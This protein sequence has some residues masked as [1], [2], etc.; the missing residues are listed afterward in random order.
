MKELLKFNH[1]GIELCLLRLN[2]KLQFAKKTRGELSF[3]LT[4]EERMLLLNVVTSFIP[5]DN[6]ITLYNL[7]KDGKKF[8]H[9]FD[10]KRNWHL[11][12][13]YKGTDLVMPSQSDLIAFNKMFNSQ[14]VVSY[15][16]G[17]DNKSSDSNFIKRIIRF[18][19]KNVI[20]M[21]AAAIT[22]T[23]G[24][25][26][27]KQN[28]EESSY[29]ISYDEI[30][31]LIQSQKEIIESSSINIDEI[32]D[33]DSEEQIAESLPEDIFEDE[34][35][36]ETKYDSYTTSEKAELIIETIKNNP[37][38]KE[39]EKQFFLSAPQFFYDNVE[40][41]NLPYVLESMKN[42]K[43]EYIPESHTNP[44]IA[45]TY[46]YGGEDKYTIKIYNTTCFSDAYKP[47]LSHEFLHAFTYHVL[48]SRARGIH[49]LTNVMMN[50]DYFGPIYWIRPYD[51]AYDSTIRYAHLLTE[52]IGVDTMRT[53]ALREDSDLLY[54]ALME[55]YPDEDKINNIIEGLSA[56]TYSSINEMDPEIYK[57]LIENVDQGLLFFYEKKYQ[58]K[59]D[60]NDYMFYI[61]PRELSERILNEVCERYEIDPEDVLV[62]IENQRSYFNSDIT[63]ENDL[64]V[65]VRRD[66]K[67]T[68]DNLLQKHPEIQ[69]TYKRFPYKNEDGTTK[70]MVETF[71]VPYPLVP[72]LTN[73]YTR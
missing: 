67:P 20:V 51:E 2:G 71:T 66:D 22:F 69:S 42:L 55:I 12:Y 57:E 32:N 48:N 47:N 11:F 40:Y 65:K 27:I 14:D 24:L 49:E 18:G 38:I 46:S 56:T 29:T 41:M 58:K 52:I 53:Y 3:N 31:D 43:I 36:D 30:A 8:K 7:K 10:K 64:R 4:R 9:L 70:Y 28:T 72:A 39:E 62:I 6:L 17:P 63:Y 35:E 5:T 73:N 44:N 61:H 15:S 26:S 37:N 33:V 19:K 59:I 50:N 25:N 68:P 1:N 54:N 34:F 23:I 13:E 60:E 45:G 16:N 21:V